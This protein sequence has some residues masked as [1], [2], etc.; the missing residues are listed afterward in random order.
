MKIAG[1]KCWK[2]KEKR[3]WKDQYGVERE[4]YYN[5]NGWGIEASEVRG[6]EEGD[7]DEELMGREKDNQKQ[8]KESKIREAKYNKKYKNIKVGGR[9]WDGSKSFNEV[10]MWE[11]GREK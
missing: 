5:R 8:I 9:P 10:K 2:E 7:M 4:K 1:L 3:G 11:Y 6:C